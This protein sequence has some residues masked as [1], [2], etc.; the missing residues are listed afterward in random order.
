MGGKFKG[1]S[2]YIHEQARLCGREANVGGG[3]PWKPSESLR[4]VAELFNLVLFIST[5]KEVTSGGKE[6]KMISIDDGAE[7]HFSRAK[8][9]LRSELPLHH[10]WDVPD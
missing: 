1:V 10:G 2:I 4:L 8:S 3:K 9:R 7:K 6:R 5:S